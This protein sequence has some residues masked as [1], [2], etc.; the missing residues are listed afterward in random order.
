MGSIFA[1]KW[2]SGV[3]VARGKVPSPFAPVSSSAPLGHPH[4]FLN[5]ICLVV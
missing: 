1:I 3:H 2:N 5:S 4:Y